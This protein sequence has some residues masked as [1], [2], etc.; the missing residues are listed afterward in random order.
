MLLR[1]AVTVGLLVVATHVAAADVVVTKEF[2]AEGVTQV[3]LRS[4]LASQAEVRHASGQHTITVS[5]TPMG[6]AEGYH[7]SDPK[8]K[9][10]PA[11]E[12]NLGFV[13]KRYGENL[14][15]S[16]KNE[17]QYIHHYYVLDHVVLILP[18]G[19]DFKLA[20][21]ELNGDGEPDLNSP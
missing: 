6:G 20:P 21:R 7:P 17:I 19:V 4:G 13:G 2:S 9:E 1:I 3:I 14:V 16:S 10:T 15:I 5:G 8:W 12:W 11:A 18:E